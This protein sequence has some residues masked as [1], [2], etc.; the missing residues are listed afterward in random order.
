MKEFQIISLKLIAHDMLL[1]SPAYHARQNLTLVMDGE[2]LL[3][4]L[5]IPRFT[6]VFISSNNPGVMELVHELKQTQTDFAVTHELP[7]HPAPP[8]RHSPVT[9]CLLYL[10]KRTFVGEAGTISFTRSAGSLFLLPEISTMWCCTGEM[11]AGEIKRARSLH[12][13]VI[14]VHETDERKDGCDF[15]KFLLSTPSDLIRDGLFRTLAVPMAAGAEH[16]LV[17]LGLLGKSLGGHTRNR[18][19]LRK[20]TQA[21]SYRKLESIIPGR[22]EIVNAKRGAS[23]SIRCSA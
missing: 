13:P 18:Q 15:D 8:S 16:R 20:V 3:Y 22:V 2:T 7:E 14:L 6:Y 19:L 23:E 12:L 17:S 10:T 1:A 5:Q 9:H 4:G 11:L 21:L